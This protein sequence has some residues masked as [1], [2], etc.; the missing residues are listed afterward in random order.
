MIRVYPHLETERD[1]AVLIVRL[2]NER[3]RN[4]LTR[5]MR[6]SLRDVVREIED[7]ASIRAVYLTGKGQSF[8]AGG[9]LN[10]LTK[11]NAPWAVHRRFRHADTLFPPLMTLDRPVVCG[12][13]GHAVGGGLGLA[14]M[15]DLVVAGESAQ[16]MAGFFR[17]GVVPDCLTLFA[18]PR[19]IGLAR[20]RNFL[21]TN[22]SWTAADALNLGIA[23]KV[24]PD[25]EVDAEG[26]A[27]AKSL[28]QGP[29]QV[30]G[31]A[32]Q[33][34]LKAFESSLDDMM[35][36]EDLGQVLAMSGPEFK[37]GLSALLEK[38]KPD[39][40][41]ASLANPVSDGLPASEPKLAAQ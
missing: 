35:L 28:A 19:L 41:A 37:E 34:L 7:D 17:L 12:V 1:G 4:T 5:E 22:G 9:D 8:C 10:M 21:F 11:A 20:T 14:L 32:K 39:Y 27:L 24:V 16:F 38:R 15:S 18:L 30:M 33:I 29:S 40:L 31:L 3:S 6:F 26:L 2:A 23:A 25:D 36:Y 13:R